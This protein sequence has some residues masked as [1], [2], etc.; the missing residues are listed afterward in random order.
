MQHQPK[1]VPAATSQHE[2]ILEMLE[3]QYTTGEL[4]QMLF[5]MHSMLKI[6]GQASEQK[7][8]ELPL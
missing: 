3:S 8:Q 1:H 7:G 6:T 4:W 2:T 5:S